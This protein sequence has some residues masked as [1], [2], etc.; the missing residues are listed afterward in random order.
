MYLIAGL[1]TEE[2]VIRRALTAFFV[3]TFSPD[4][5]H[6]VPTLEEIA[7]YEEWCRTHRPD[8]YASEMSIRGIGALIQES[9]S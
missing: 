5:M 3:K 8:L 4:A 7:Q 2:E 6:D 9:S 1:I